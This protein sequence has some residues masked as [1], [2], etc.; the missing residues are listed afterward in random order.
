MSSKLTIFRNGLDVILKKNIVDTEKRLVEI[1]VETNFL[2]ENEEYDTLA[3]AYIKITITSQKLER[4][5][6]EAI[7]NRNF[8]SAHRLIKKVEELYLELDERCATFVKM[9]KAT[10]NLYLLKRNC[11][12]ESHERM[13][14]WFDD[15]QLEQSNERII[16]ALRAAR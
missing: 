4:A 6:Y 7:F 9:G 13:K 15:E 1:Y 8:K 11:Q 14:A 12:K 16:A 3:I 5:V 2:K 10:E